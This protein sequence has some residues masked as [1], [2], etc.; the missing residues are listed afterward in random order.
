VDND[1]NALILK[2]TNRE[3][4]KLKLSVGCDPDW[5]M[6]HIAVISRG[7]A[8]CYSAGDTIRTDATTSRDY[9]SVCTIT[10]INKWDP[11]ATSRI[12]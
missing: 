6:S 4:Y 1:R 11:D 3:A 10:R 2:M 12:E 9:R 5:A 7:G 8:S